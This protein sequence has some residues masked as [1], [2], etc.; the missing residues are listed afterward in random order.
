[1]NKLRSRKSSTKFCALMVTDVRP[2]VSRNVLWVP[3]AVS[4]MD[5]SGRSAKNLTFLLSIV[6]VTVVLQHT[7]HEY[8]L[9]ALRQKNTQADLAVLNALSL[10]GALQERNL[11]NISAV[12][13]G[14]QQVVGIR[15][16]SN[17]EGVFPTT[18]ER[19]SRL[20]FQQCLAAAASEV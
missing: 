19:V 20:E 15:V 17:S 4:V 13:S 5:E 6:L 11:Q 10:L 7:V 1:M 9:G 2:T 12:G 14:L 3:M 16:P 18:E 8:S